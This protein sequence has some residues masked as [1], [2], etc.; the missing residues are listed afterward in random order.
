MSISSAISKQKIAGTSSAEL[1]K[2]LQKHE[3]FL[4]SQVGGLRADLKFRNLTGLILN[5]VDFRQADLAG[6]K[7]LSVQMVG[8]RLSDAS[9][10]GADL[11]MANLHRADLTRAD[12][13]G[14]CMRGAI[15]TESLMIE[16]DLRKGKLMRQGD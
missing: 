14:A 15:L 10:F 1:S 11:R 4:S 3:L 9:L 16:A 12:L 2:I 8:S 6:T 5:Y 13:R 7:L